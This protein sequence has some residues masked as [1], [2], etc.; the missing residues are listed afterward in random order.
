MLFIVELND[1]PMI[2]LF[3]LYYSVE[4]SPSRARK[5]PTDILFK[6]NS[7]FF[8]HFAI[9]KSQDKIKQAGKAKCFFLC[10]AKIVLVYSEKEKSG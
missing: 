10:Y 9:L 7:F 3:T 6:K 5:I 2:L 4:R 1:E 8:C